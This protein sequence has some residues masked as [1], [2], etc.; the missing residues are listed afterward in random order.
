MLTPCIPLKT[1]E[2]G[3]LLYWCRIVGYARSDITAALHIE[4]FDRL[5]TAQAITA[6]PKS[7]VASS[8]LAGTVPAIFLPFLP[9]LCHK[10]ARL[11]TDPPVVMA[12]HRHIGSIA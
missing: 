8:F 11:T 6:R 7:S 2:I 5:L 3:L 1:F 10:A 9:S 12:A 4:L